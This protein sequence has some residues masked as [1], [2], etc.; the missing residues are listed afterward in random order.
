MLPVQM[1]VAVGRTVVESS[2]QAEPTVVERRLSGGRQG[3]EMVA[4]LPVP[5]QAAHY[6]ERKADVLH[7][8]KR[9]GEKGALH[10]MSALIVNS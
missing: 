8:L 1:E 4:A 3:Q 10:A 5:L 9:L 7:C 6:G 2:E